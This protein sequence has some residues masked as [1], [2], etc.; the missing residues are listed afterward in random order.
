MA[1]QDEDAIWE[2]V[3]FCAREGYLLRSML[4]YLRTWDDPVD[5]KMERVSGW[6]NEIALQLGNPKLAEDATDLLKKVRGLPPSIRAQML[7][8]A[9]GQAQAE[10]FGVNS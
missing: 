8:I 4:E 1:D 5:K 10:Y 2:F 9:L 3:E 6:R 7:R